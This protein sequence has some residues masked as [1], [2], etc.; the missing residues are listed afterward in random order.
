MPNLYT[1]E[2]VP[3]APRRRDGKTIQLASATY[4]HAAVQESAAVG[5]FTAIVQPDVPRK[6]S[7]T[8]LA[9]WQGGDITIV[10]LGAN[11]QRITE[12]IADSAGSTV[13]GTKV[14]ATIYSIEKELV[15]GTTDTVTIGVLAA[16][17]YSS[18]FNPGRSFGA[19]LDIETTGTLNGTWTLWRSS[20]RM[21]GYKGPSMEDDTDWVEE[22]KFKDTAANPDYTNPAGATT[23]WA[24]EVS[25][26]RN[27]L[28]RLKF[29]AASG[30]GD[31]HAYC[32]MSEKGR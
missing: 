10:G 7:A 17:Y 20:K 30:A 27:R 23:K 22:L 25:G 12:V 28:W 11:G 5:S 8:F 19:G 21:N 4:I 6:L 26:T 13:N 2:L 9:G 31:I 16:N 14:F 32:E 24:T 29:V 1:T 18:P 15:A 3:S